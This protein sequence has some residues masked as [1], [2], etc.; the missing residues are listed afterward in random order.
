[1]P[2][3]SKQ[4]A[5]KGRAQ[6][7]RV[8]DHA[9]TTSGEAAHPEQRPASENPKWLLGTTEAAELLGLSPH[10][11]SKWRVTGMGPPFQSLGRRCLYDPERLRR[12]ATSREMKSTSERMEERGRHD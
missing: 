9:P 8:P 2:S 1:M 4:F 12:W 10:T 7:L 6:F 3:R 11:L 5:N